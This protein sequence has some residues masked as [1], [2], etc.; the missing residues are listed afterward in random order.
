M[1]NLEWEDIPNLNYA[2]WYRRAKVYGGWL[3]EATTD[4]TH[5]MNYEG[6]KGGM[7]SGYDW[8]IALTFVPDQLH[9]WKI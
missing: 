4:V 3:V 8:R 2:T 5:D 7:D 9:Q 1:S 6:G